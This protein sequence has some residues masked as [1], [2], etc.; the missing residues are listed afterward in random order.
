MGKETKT[1]TRAYNGKIN[2]FFRG[3]LFKRNIFFYVFLY[4]SPFVRNSIGQA[5]GLTFG[6]Y[7]YKV[8]PVLN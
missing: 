3:C 8:V 2:N 6:Y 7:I 1:E 5:G 4:E